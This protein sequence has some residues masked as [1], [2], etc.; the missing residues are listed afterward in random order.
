MRSD[1]KIYF[2]DSF[3]LMT[4]TR[5]QMKEKFAVVLETESDINAFLNNPHI[6]F[7]GSTNA[8]VLLLSE[9]PG[10]CICRL[11]DKVEIV[12]AGGGIV[13]NERDELL[14]IFRR[15]KWDLPK[16]KI[17]LNE[18]IRDG[19]VR[20][21]EE[22]TGV[23]IAETEPKPI[24]TYHAYTLKGKNCLKQTEWYVMKAQPAQLN[25]VPQT[26]EDIE[27]VTWVPRT[28][29]KNYCEGCY[30]LIWD[31]IERYVL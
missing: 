29:L 17:E 6:L 4:A 2:N 23:K 9:K 21:V 27:Q 13:F 24:T 19:A 5:P 11:M 10:D 28:Q 20:E 8:P 18:K 22:E 3:L 25:L 31:L 12:I 15:G 7:D 1:Y 30:P 16:G 26:E 14:L